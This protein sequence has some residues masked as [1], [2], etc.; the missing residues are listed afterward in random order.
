MQLPA[1][2]SDSR[3]TALKG[4]AGPPALRAGGEGPAMQRVRVGLSCTSSLD[5]E[6][7]LHGRGPDTVTALIML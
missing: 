7:S 6:L 1:G 4:A 2:S 3:L 5:P